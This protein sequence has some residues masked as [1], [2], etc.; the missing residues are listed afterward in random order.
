MDFLKSFNFLLIWGGSAAVSLAIL[1]YDLCK[2][3][4]H[5]GSFMKLVWFLTVLYSS[6][7]GLLIYFYSG[8]K[9]I[10]EDDDWRKGFRSVAHCY[11]G[12]GAGEVTGVV[13]AVGLLSLNNWWVAGI[14]F[15]L[16][17]VFG[18]A[19][20]MGPLMQEGESFWQALKDAA[21]S[22]SA[23]IAVM[24][25]VAIS[26][27]LLLAKDAK[28]HE[29]LFWSSLIISL[30]CGLIAAY[31]VNMWLIKKGIKKGMHNPKEE[32]S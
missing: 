10:K 6:C 2:N 18:F 20:T 30:T 32:I 3:N 13:I 27:D 7:I 29:P 15:T 21:Y 16:A 4:R 1:L 8:R 19:M 22:E 14:T 5:L 28:I 17:Y 31:P 23:S 9:Q 25:I 11:S 12:C 26:T 24:E